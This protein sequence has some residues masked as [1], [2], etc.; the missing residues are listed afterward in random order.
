MAISVRVRRSRSDEWEALK[1]LRLEGLRSDPLAFG[2]TFALEVAFDDAQW[3]ERAT[4]GSESAW[5]S[6]WVAEAAPG[7]LVGSAV[8]AD[9]EGTVHVFAMW[10]EP[11]VRGRGI[12]GR[13]LDTGMEWARSAFPGRSVV[14]EVN[15]RQTAAVRLYLSRGFRP[16]GTVRPL[17]HTPGEVLHEMRL[18]GTNAPPP[19]ERSP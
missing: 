18:E 6:Q 10:V 16:T 1:Q 12:A 13:L 7:R 5:I 9:L 17:E 2:S 19:A 14:L 15:P 8:V 11:S 4:S 3:K